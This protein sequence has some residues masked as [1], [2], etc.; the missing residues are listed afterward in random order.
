[1]HLS[2]SH[3]PFRHLNTPE[4]ARRYQR[5]HSLRR[6]C[7]QQI[8]C[9]SEQL[10]TAAQERGFAEDQALH[11]DLCQIMTQNTQS[12]SDTLPSG[13]FARNFWDNQ[14]QA[15]SLKDARE[16]RWCLYLRHLS[17][18][19]YE[20]LRETGVIKLPSQRTLRDYT[21]HT[22][23]TVG[24]SKEVDKQLQ[25]AAKLSSCPEREK[26]VTIIIDEMHLREDLA[27]DKHT[28]IMFTCKG[29]H[30]ELLVY[31]LKP[32][33]VHFPSLSFVKSLLQPVFSCVHRCP[34]WYLFAS[35]TSIL[36][37]LNTRSK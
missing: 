21:H 8:A 27:Y 36:T 1:M 3:T 37:L 11:D 31:C 25:V 5:E 26:C 32:Y 18:S 2:S 14:K 24:F 33:L 15:A 17:S 22:K 12:V 9:L 4:K 29:T 7:Q 16:M 20:S 28:G 23:A 30:T 10:S 6:S 34:Q 35:E 13:S 19:T